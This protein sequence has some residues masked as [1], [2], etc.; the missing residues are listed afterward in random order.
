MAT[1]NKWSK[2]GE[3]E[4]H[5][6]KAALDAKV[7]CAV[8]GNGESS[9]TAYPQISVMINGVPVLFEAARNQKLVV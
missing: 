7:F 5:L 1:E 6:T 4:V 2:I 9:F 3:V 8:I